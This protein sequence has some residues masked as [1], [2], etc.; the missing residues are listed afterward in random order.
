MLN[1]DRVRK[2]LFFL[3]D[4]KLNFGFFFLKVKKISK[5]I[6]TLR[7]YTFRSMVETK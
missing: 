6:P 7:T 5:I 2:R 1:F 3:H 4:D